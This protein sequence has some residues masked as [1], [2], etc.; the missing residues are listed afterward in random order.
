MGVVQD[1]RR[2][3]RIPDALVIRLR[4]DFLV[5][6]ARARGVKRWAILVA[7]G[8][9]WE[10]VVTG[11]AYRS[12]GPMADSPAGRS[13]VEFRVFKDPAEAATWV[14]GGPSD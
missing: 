3:V 4:I 10:I 12:P 11:D 13:S 2:T 14:R 6:R 7:G 1:W 5:A 9:R 8:A